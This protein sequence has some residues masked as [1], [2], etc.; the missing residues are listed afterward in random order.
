MGTYVQQVP[1]KFV[2]LPVSTSTPTYLDVQSFPF[3]L[4]VS[5]LP[6]GGGTLN[7]FYS[8]TP[9]AAGKLEAASW[10]QWPSGVQTGNFSDAVISPVSGL[11]F[12]A[13]TANGV[14]EVNG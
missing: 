13:A 5:V 8:T 10:I 6:A 12:V 11:K 14:A 4:T 2:S 7:V 9:N 3:P 1:C